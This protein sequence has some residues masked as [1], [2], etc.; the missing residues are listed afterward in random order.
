VAGATDDDD[1][2]DGMDTL[3]LPSM[4]CCCKGDDTTAEVTKA[5]S[6]DEE[7]LICGCNGGRL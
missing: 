3:S 6:E 7:E 5:V 4:R 2:A 1:G